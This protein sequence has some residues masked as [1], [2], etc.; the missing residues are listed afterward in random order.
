MFRLLTLLLLSS[1]I[2]ALEIKIPE[3]FHGHWD[4]RNCERVTDSILYLAES[5]ME[6]YE[7]K[8]EILS[9]TIVS[10]NSISIEYR[11]FG[12]DAATWTDKMDLHLIDGNIVTYH[13]QTGEPW[14]R[15][16]CD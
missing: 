16:K 10:M 11:Y 8:H 13:P 4:V 12:T 6:A 15:N 7:G 1:S 5:S 2:E 3:Q 9:V 14:I